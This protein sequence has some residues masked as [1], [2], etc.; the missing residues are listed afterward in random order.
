[1]QITVAYATPDKQVELPLELDQ[2][3]TIEQALE[4]SGI[5]ALFPE[6]DRANLQ[7]GVFSK[8]A[9]LTDILSE[10]DRVEIYRPLQVDPKEARRLRAAKKTNYT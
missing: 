4:A 10:N 2:G 8:K 1:M 6:I 7:V 5:Y 3:S 9:K